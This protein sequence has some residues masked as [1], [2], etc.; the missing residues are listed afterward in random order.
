MMR[1]YRIT[2]G[3]RSSIY[4]EEKFR[5][6]AEEQATE[7][8]ILLDNSGHVAHMREMR[9]AHKILVRKHE[10]ESEI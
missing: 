7:C 2:R 5:T 10:M 4:M 8:F 9:S 6:H 1:K 3:S